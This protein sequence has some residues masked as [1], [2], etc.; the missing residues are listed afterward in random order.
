MSKRQRLCALSLVLMVTFSVPA[1][2]WGNVGHMAVAFVAYQKLTP[3]ARNRVDTLV[4]LNPKFNAWQAMIPA[5]TSAARRRMMLFMIAATWADQIKG[6]GEHTADGTHNG[7]RLPTD[8]TADRN[9]GYTDTAMHK[10][11]HFVDRPF[12]RDGTPL[13]E[14]PVPNAETQIDALRQV[15]ASTETAALKSYDLV[16]LMHLVGDVHQPLHATARFTSTQPEGDDG[17]NGVKL[18]SLPCKNNLHSF[19]D[20]LPGSADDVKASIAPAIAYGQSL[21]AA[22]AASVNKL[23]TSIW[24]TES[25]D[26]TKSSVYK[27]PIGAGPGPFTITTTYR[28]AARNLARQRVALAGARLARILNNELTLP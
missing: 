27:T 25:F 10:Y 19:W 17:G 12:S 13:Q 7:N 22:P 18:C 26:A 8:G 1:Y 23:N 16:W 2:G 6:D 14:P 20:G 11:W 5:G 4:R 21:A 9:T 15:L 3:A 24:I 28:N